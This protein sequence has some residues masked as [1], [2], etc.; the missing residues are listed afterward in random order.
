MGLMM[1][2]S[3]T[4]M[5]ACC[6]YCGRTT[7]PDD[8][9]HLLRLALPIP[10]LHS[11][12]SLR[13]RWRRFGSDSRSA[14]PSQFHRCRFA[15]R[16]GRRQVIT[17]RGAAFVCLG[18]TDQPA[19]AG[20]VAGE[21]TAGF[22]ERLRSGRTCHSRRRRTCSFGAA[23]GFAIATHADN[24]VVDASS[25]APR[26][27]RGHL[28]GWPRP[29]PIEPP[30]QHRRRWPPVI[31]RLADFRLLSTACRSIRSES[32]MLASP[33]PALPDQRCAPRGCRS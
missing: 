20:P 17:S 28:R 11:D 27:D 12:A 8:G 25:R 33:A 3:T 7:R 22:S 19:G 30:D 15:L 13:I 14:A 32:T 21:V 26:R 2:W 9:S 16:P 31:V 18:E 10:Q 24:S 1:R 6:F 4:V 23:S 29:N 5:A